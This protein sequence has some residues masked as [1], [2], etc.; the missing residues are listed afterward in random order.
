M[1]EPHCNSRIWAVL[2]VMQWLRCRSS[3]CLRGCKIFGIRDGPWGSMR[4]LTANIH[5]YGLGWAGSGLDSQ[6]RKGSLMMGKMTALREPA[7]KSGT[8]SAS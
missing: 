6:P 2:Q 4:M 5:R 3:T 8:P 7:E 1:F